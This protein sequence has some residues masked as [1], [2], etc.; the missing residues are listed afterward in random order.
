M[1]VSTFS[2]E[3]HH[4]VRVATPPSHFR[5]PL[6][7]K[8]VMLDP[9]ITSDGNV[10]ERNE[11]IHW[12][13][14]YDFCPVTMNPLSINDLQSNAQLKKE[15]DAWRLG[16]TDITKKQQTGVYDDAETTRRMKSDKLCLSAHGAPARQNSDRSVAQHSDYSMY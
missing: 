13:N 3:S 7:Q 8:G 9:V 2:N 11:I 1:T 12:L 16:K 14:E 15:I 6:A 4:N 10:F 5:C